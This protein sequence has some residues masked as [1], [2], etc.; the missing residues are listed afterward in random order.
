MWQGFRNSPLKLF[1]LICDISITEGISK[2][3]TK[4]TEAIDFLKF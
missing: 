4:Y 3:F 2:N 1:Q